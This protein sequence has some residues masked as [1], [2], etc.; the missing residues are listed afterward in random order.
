MYLHIMCNKMTVGIVE[1]RIRTKPVCGISTMPPGLL[2]IAHRLH[3]AS[4][5]IDGI[6]VYSRILSWKLYNKQDFAVLYQKYMRVST[7]TMKL[8]SNAKM[9][10]NLAGQAFGAGVLL[11]CPAAASLCLLLADRCHS[12]LLA[13]SATGSARKRPHFDN[14]PFMLNLR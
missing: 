12:F 3:L 11:R 7:Q 9:A 1:F 5:V 2:V 4:Y 14:L 10:K 6:L 13:S 8:Y